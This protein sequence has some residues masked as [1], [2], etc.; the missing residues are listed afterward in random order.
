[1]RTTVEMPAELMQAAKVRAAERGETLKDL[2]TRAVARELHV[3]AGPARTGRLSLPLIG[4]GAS[5][6]VDVTNAD[7]EGALDAEDIDR[8]VDR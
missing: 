6:S 8:Y 3:P 7:I 1:M 4:R 2:V 5:P